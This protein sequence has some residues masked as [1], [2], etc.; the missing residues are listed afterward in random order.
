MNARHKA[1]ITCCLFGLILAGCSREKPEP[2]REDVGRKVDELTQK[3]AELHRLLAA[4]RVPE[5]GAET[6]LR[7]W[8]KQHLVPG[9]TTLGEV[10]QLFGADCFDLD[11][12]DRED[13]LTIQ[14]SLNEVSGKKL[15][16]DFTC[17]RVARF[18]D[19]RQWFGLP[20]L[21]F[22]FRPPAS[23]PVLFPLLNA[24]IGYSICGFCP[25]ILVEDGRWR[26]EGKMLPGAIGPRRESQDTLVLPRARPRQGKVRVRLANWAPEFE[27]IDQV[28]LGVVSGR[29]GQQ[30]DV[31]ARGE[32]YLWV[33][34]S[35]VALDPPEV[36]GGC[37]H[38][39][40]RRQAAAS[41][42]VLVLELRNTET[43][44]NA[45]C[46]A[47]REKAPAL[48]DAALAVE[49]DGGGQTLPAVGTKFF[50]RVVIPLPPGTEEVRLSGPAGLWWV[51]RAWIGQGGPAAAVR[52][53]VPTAV[54]G[55]GASSE[56][57]AARD[58]RRLC[59][60]REE[61]ADLTFAI[62]AGAAA[63]AERQLFLLRLSGYYDFTAE[64]LSSGEPD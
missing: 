29:E 32:P 53:F 38:W 10:R 11:R 63:A 3:V 56:L 58:Q 34:E 9:R 48:P 51:R 33:P 4:L 59:L 41:P 27:Q 24:E 23:A 46:R 39:S 57:V 50:R 17:D 2:A 45:T 37:D 49:F 14:Y 36:H 15:V 12:P 43:F 54:H 6:R 8:M 42:S 35:G 19:F 64:A 13:I 28:E 62:P 18:G 20:D 55:P 26:L 7:A 60:R 52:W 16:L 47:V 5:P 1:L 30:V 31:D 21:A 61:Q 44:Q 40:I 25:H 22:L